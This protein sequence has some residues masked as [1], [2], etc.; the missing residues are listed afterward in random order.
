MPTP[1]AGEYDVTASPYSA[2][3]NSSTYADQTSAIK[4]A[5]DDA[6]DGGGGTVYIPNGYYTVSSTILDPIKASVYRGAKVTIRGDD[7]GIAG[8]T[9]DGTR[10]LLRAAVSTTTPIFKV[11]GNDFSTNRAVGFTLKDL[12]L[13]GGGYGA[14]WISFLM[15]STARLDRVN[16][17]NTLGNGIYGVEWTDSV[18]HDCWFDDVA[19]ATSSLP[20]VDLVTKSSPATGEDPA[21]QN[22]RFEAVRFA[23]HRYYAVY[24]EDGT[25][26]IHFAGCSW[27][28]NPSMTS[29][30]PTY[31]AANVRIYNSYVANFAGCYFVKSGSQHIS[32]AGSSNLCIT[33]SSFHDAWNFG[34]YL[35]NTKYC[36]ITGNS[37][38]TQAGG[39]G[40]GDP[41]LIPPRGG[42]IHEVQSGLNNE[43]SLNVGGSGA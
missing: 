13:D 24:M 41:T 29:G 39:V 10:L 14:R 26:F 8:G 3:R 6:L 36:M 40:N 33:T 31:G 22:L 15:A 7:P 25:K 12:T 34:I 4:Q 5:I 27:F 30:S 38:A 1:P 35:D 18:V 17:V 42:N 21:C 37:F 43:I 11:H 20:T 9:T 2:V 28:G 23:N 16:F 19:S 32:C